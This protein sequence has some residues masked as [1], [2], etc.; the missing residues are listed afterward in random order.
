ME[1]IA[2]GVLDHGSKV[3]ERLLA[4]IQT[5]GEKGIHVD[6]TERSGGP[7]TFL[8]LSIPEPG[9][10]IPQGQ[11]D[12]LRYHVASALADSIV[13]DIEA[14]LIEK[15]L[16]SRYSYFDDEEREKIAE[17]VL[18]ALNRRS[19]GDDQGQ[20]QAITRRR[21]DI[22]FALLDYL[23]TSDCLI[24]DGFMRFRLKRYMEQL[25]TAADS[26]VDDFMLEKEYNEFIRLLK[27]FVDVQEPKIEEIHVI[28]RPNGHFRLLDQNGKAVD[29]DYLEG[30]PVEPGQSDVDHEDLLISALIT[31]SPK[32]IIL[33]GFQG[34]NAN[35]TITRVFDNRVSS[36][37]GCQICEKY[38][39]RLHAP[40]GGHSDD[41]T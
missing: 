41:L 7:L 36:C 33:H 29:S 2:I 20:V 27:Y 10:G 23:D 30:A 31:V 38:L 6:I 19:Q 28:A 25:E 8:C 17:Y 9:Q 14:E 21:N 35:E 37:P 39:T 15:T 34:K 11:R 18:D 40:T 12:I 3:Q 16:R 22:L 5:L 24:L 1:I 32:R 4:K 26:A 13:F